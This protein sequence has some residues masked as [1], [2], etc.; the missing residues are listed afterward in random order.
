MEVR[1][2]RLEQIKSKDTEKIKDQIPRDL[3]PEG[4]ILHIRSQRT[5]SAFVW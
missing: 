1:R 2:F 5:Y 4:S 3:G